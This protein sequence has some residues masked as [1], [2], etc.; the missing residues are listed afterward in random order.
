[1]SRLV[2]FFI[3]SICLGY[4]RNFYSIYENVLDRK[5]NTQFRYQIISFIKFKL[6]IV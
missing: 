1:M 5:F 6:Y 3:L 4:Y 2:I